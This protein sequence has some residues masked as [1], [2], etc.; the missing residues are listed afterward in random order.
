MKKGFEQIS[1]KD[2]VM[3][4]HKTTPEELMQQY[5]TDPELRAEV[6]EILADGKI[7]LKEFLGFAKKHDLKVSTKDFP[8]ALRKAKEMKLIAEDSEENE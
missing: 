3:A 1:R 6:E 7:T 4:K 5:E 8:K 2:E